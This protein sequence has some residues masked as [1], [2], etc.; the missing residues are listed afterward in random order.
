MSLSLNSR[1]NPNP[2]EIAAYSL[3]VAQLSFNYGFQLGIW[4]L[5]IPTDMKG[6]NKLSRESSCLHLHDHSEDTV[7]LSL[8]D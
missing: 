4:I 7:K 3:T 1:C 5:E 2:H 6:L 8:R